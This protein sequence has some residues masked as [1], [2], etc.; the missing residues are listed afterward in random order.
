MLF[1]MWNFYNKLACD[2]DFHAVQNLFI[3]G[4]LGAF[5]INLIQR[6]Y[7]VGTKCYYTGVVVNLYAT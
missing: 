2:Q 4:I 7:T 5:D 6:L 1:A 3:I